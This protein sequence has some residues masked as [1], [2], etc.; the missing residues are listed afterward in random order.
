MR[1]FI[2]LICAFSLLV[3]SGYALYFLFFEAAR[4]K[5]LW[6]G[7]A[8]AFLVVSVYWIWEDL[9]RPQGDIAQE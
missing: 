3:A 4:F 2:S 8:G 5:I 9:V 6:A 7:G 1:K